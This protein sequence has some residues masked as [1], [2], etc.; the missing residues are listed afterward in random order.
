[1]QELAFE[2]LVQLVRVGRFPADKGDV[3]LKTTLIPRMARQVRINMAKAEADMD[4][5][6]D[7][8]YEFLREHGLV[9]G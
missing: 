4:E 6:E 9:T 1:V 7:Y 5:A 2:M 8:S 3:R